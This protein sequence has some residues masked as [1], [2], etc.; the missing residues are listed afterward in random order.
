MKTLKLTV[1]I[2]TMLIINSCTSKEESPTEEPQEVEDEIE[3]PPNVSLG[4]TA[5]YPY[6]IPFSLQQLLLSFQDKS[7]ND[8]VKGI[9]FWSN[10]W[11]AFN[12]VDSTRL[13]YTGTEG[14]ETDAWGVVNSELYT[15]EYA[16][17]GIPYDKNILADYDWEKPPLGFRRGKPFSKKYPELNGNYD[18]LF[19]NTVSRTGK[20][21][22]KL[23]CP[24]LFGDDAVHDIDT[25][26]KYEEDIEFPI[27]YRI[28]FGGKEIT[29]ITYIY[30]PPYKDEFGAIWVNRNPYSVAT[31]VFDK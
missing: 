17:N 24:Y 30:D 4:I 21:T 19:F 31:L 9:G 27:C 28:E 26:W 20:I 23:S 16:F 7:G 14:G 29:E 2:L 3:I 13:V 10:Y 18:Y 25:W 11:L 1:L 8:L 5:F 15:L 6:G 12:P 22:F